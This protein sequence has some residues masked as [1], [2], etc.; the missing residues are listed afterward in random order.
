MP[1]AR[2]VF[3]PFARYTHFSFIF[4]RCAARIFHVPGSS[5]G[6]YSMLRG[7]RRNIGT[8][9]LYCARR[10]VSETMRV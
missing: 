9:N 8:S 6:R 3:C 1:G 5:L 2:C 7:C 10:R 4:A